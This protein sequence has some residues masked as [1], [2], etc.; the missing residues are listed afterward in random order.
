[1]AA[2]RGLLKRE[3]AKLISDHAFYLGE[4]WAAKELLGKDYEQEKWRKS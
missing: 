1:M 4:E 3:A 2:D